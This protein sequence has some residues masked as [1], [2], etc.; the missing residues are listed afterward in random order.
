MYCAGGGASG[1]LHIWETSTGRL[2]RSWHGHYKR[3]SCLAFTDHGRE[4][5]TGGDDTIVT[6]WLLAEVLDVGTTQSSPAGPTPF[7]SWTDHTLPVTAV[8]VGAGG[9]NALIASTSLDRSIKVRSLGTGAV[10]RT[11]ALPSPL[12]SLVLDP[13][14][15]ALY[16]GS[17]FGSVYDVSLVG[18]VGPEG[19]EYVEMGKSHGEKAVT[20]L[21]LSGDASLLVS[22]GEDSSVRVWD[23][24]SRQIV[25]TLDN[26][27]KGAVSGLIVCDRP[28]NMPV[29]AVG[30][31]KGPGRPQALSQLSKYPGTVSGAMKPW[32]EALVILDSTSELV[33]GWRGV[34]SE[35]Q[36]GSPD[37]TA[38]LT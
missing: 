38:A 2:L 16:V 21:A 1:A 14:E 12:T 19:Q 33:G 18:W 13:G 31:G 36:G 7:R 5:I 9:I 25:R 32:D 30:G 22:G 3:V 26:P 6:A 15:H 8:A 27:A 10:L 35:A 29:G 24:R 4:L 23:L 20:A 11:I 17:A 34:L 37:G 28:P